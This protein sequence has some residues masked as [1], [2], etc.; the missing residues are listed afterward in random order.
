[1]IIE[2]NT[3]ISKEQ[4][5]MHAAPSD[6]MCAPEYPRYRT[7]IF[8]NAFDKTRA[9]DDK[10]KGKYMIQKNFLSIIIWNN[11]QSWYCLS[12]CNSASKSYLRWCVLKCQLQ[13][14]SLRSYWD[15]AWWN[16]VSNGSTDGQSFLHLFIQFIFEMM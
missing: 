7:K 1:M 6:L 12:C 15:D 2:Q 3:M 10:N 9:K 8:T 5:L 11:K 16:D 13:S 14:K 4:L